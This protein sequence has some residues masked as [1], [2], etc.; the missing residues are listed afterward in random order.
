[1]G[2]V[3]LEE[4]AIYRGVLVEIVPLEEAEQGEVLIDSQDSPPPRRTSGSKRKPPTA[5]LNTYK[6]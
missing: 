4:T 2:G 3:L 5:Q 6:K 1:M